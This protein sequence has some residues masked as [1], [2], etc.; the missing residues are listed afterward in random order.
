MDVMVSRESKSSFRVNRQALKYLLYEYSVQDPKNDIPLIH[1]MAGTACGRPLYSLREDFC[2]TFQFSREWVKQ[3][4]RHTALSLDLDPQ[5]LAFGRMRAA[6]DLTDDER[7][8]IR[9]LR[10][11]VL[12]A[13]RPGVDM[14]WVGN[15]SFYFIKER[16]KLVEYLR[17]ARR[18][19]KP[20]SAIVLEMAGGPEFT[21]A[22]SEKRSFPVPG[23][24]R[25]RY[26]WEQGDFNPIT[27][28]ARYRIHYE[29]A[30][31]NRMRNAFTYDWRVW[32]LPEVRDAASE[33]GFAKVATF[34]E[35]RGGQGD[36]Y[37]ETLDGD[38]DPAWI[39][40]VIG[41]TS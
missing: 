39:S 28:E 32:S 34:V 38:N 14:I 10:R 36:R 30:R 21:K 20:R 6:Q 22:M 27:A 37:V 5:P 1:E 23:V 33:A 24:G 9:V 7:R 2:G 19:L 13:T 8:R 11:D 17:V 35:K 15:F 25:F 31:G 29:D 40:Y 26:I 4:A 16:S 18:S 41:V 12:K 3:S